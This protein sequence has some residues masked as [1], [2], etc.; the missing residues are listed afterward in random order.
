MKLISQFFAEA[1]IQIREGKASCT[2][3]K[4][5]KRQLDDMTYL[6]AEFN[7]VKGEIWIHQRGRLSYSR[8]IPNIAHQKIRNV[9]FSP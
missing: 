5:M 4:I 7:I 1:A 3:G 9:I 2:K 8:E 6:A